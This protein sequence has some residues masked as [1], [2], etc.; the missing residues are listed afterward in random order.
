MVSSL[1]SCSGLFCYTEAKTKFI[2]LFF[3][4]LITGSK[5]EAEA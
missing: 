1:K 5:P 4:A 2:S 3:S